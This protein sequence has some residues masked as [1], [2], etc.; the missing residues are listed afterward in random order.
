MKLKLFLY[1][2]CKFVLLFF[3]FS[4]LFLFPRKIFAEEISVNF[5][6]HV[7]IKDNGSLFFEDDIVYKSKKNEDEV[8]RS[9]YK[10]KNSKIEKLTISIGNEKLTLDTNAKKGYSKSYTLDEEEDRILIKIFNPF[11]STLN[12]KMSYEIS[13]LGKIGS[14]T[15]YFSYTFFKDVENKIDFFKGDLFFENGI[16]KKTSPFLYSSGKK[17]IKNVK[18]GLEIKVRDIKKG[19]YLFLDLGFEEEA[20]P[21]STQRTDMTLKDLKEIHKNSGR[22][23]FLKG[24]KNKFSYFISTGATIFSFLIFLYAIYLF[25]LRR[26]T[27]E[28]DPNIVSSLEAAYLLKG[29]GSL[30]NLILANILSLQRI[31]ALEIKKEDYVTKSGKKKISYLF[32]LNPKK[33]SQ[34]QIEEKT[35]IENFFKDET[36]ISTRDIAE[37][38]KAGPEFY[39]QFNEY[40]KSLKYKL[41]NLNLLYKIDT[42]KKKVIKIS[43][44]AIIVYSLSVLNFKPI[45]I[46]SST[47]FTIFSISLMF[48]SMLYKTPKGNY[49]VNFYNKKTVE[50]EKNEDFE[51]YTNEDIIA[52]ISLGIDDK[53]IYEALGK[54][55]LSNFFDRSIF[56]TFKEDPEKYK[57]FSENFYNL[58]LSDIVLKSKK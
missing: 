30:Q 4:S 50:Y 45:N 17:E 22:L 56:K 43:L 9:I 55:P 15:G 12:L 18:N 38:I 32:I 16:S 44:L 46:I 37:K 25:N 26:K 1:K 10:P 42:Y 31:K 14:D 48:L 23:S 40:S 35:F 24:D 19:G 27:K 53:K 2:F 36:I 7:L 8:I 47:I 49:L 6:T 28:E 11:E 58:F 33:L 29:D 20:I 5:D 57:I 41:E 34:L 21:F 39:L 13:N 54:M 3:I 51:S 52:M